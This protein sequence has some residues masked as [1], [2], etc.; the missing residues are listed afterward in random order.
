MAKWQTPEGVAGSTELIRVFSGSVRPRQCPTEIAVKARPRMAPMNRPA[1][2]RKTLELNPIKVLMSVL[3]LVE[4]EEL[5]LCVALSRLPTPGSAGAKLAGEWIAP[6]HPGLRRWVESAARNYLSAF[7]GDTGGRLPPTWRAIPDPWV[8]QHRL[9]TPD[10]RGALTYETCVWGRRYEYR[11]ADGLVR[12]LRLPTMNKSGTRTRDQAEIAVAAFVTARGR[13]VLERW[14]PKEGRCYSLREDLPPEENQPPAY[15]RVVEVGCGDGKP[16]V[17]FEGSSAEAVQRHRN[18]ALP[19]LAQAVDGHGYRPGYDCDDCKLRVDC[20]ELP[21]SPG[22]LGIEDRE[23]PRRSWSITQARYYAVCPAKEHFRSLLLPGDFATENSPAALRGKAVHAFL[24]RLHGRTPRR[25]CSP[26]DAPPD[27]QTWQAAGWPLTDEQAELASRMVS[28]HWR[29]CP[30][31][32]L[33]PDARIESERALVV[34]DPAAD[35]LVTATPDLLY[36][37]GGVWFWRETKTSAATASAET[38]PEL[39]ERFPQLALAVLMFVAGV[40]RG[41]RRSIELEVLRPDSPD[42]RIIDPFHPHHGERAREIVH[43]YAAAWH[44]DGQA[45]PNPTPDGCAACEFR[46]WCPCPA[47]MPDAH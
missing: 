13:R 24:E 41:G 39:L 19:A 6:I 16:T 28:R 31:R 10:H 17:L 37:R 23:R 21:R 3:D 8:E 40:R 29:T 34:D 45:V 38:V 43:R 36:E 27:Q 47:E 30:L 4:H 12:E 44:G 32:G 42:I 7:P 26:E 18:L 25:P 22:L 33:A 20:R 35:V 1:W 15:V 9:R 5:D 46:A 11:S 14:F 2:K